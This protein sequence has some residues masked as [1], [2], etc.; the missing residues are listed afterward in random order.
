VFGQFR[1]AAELH[2]ARLSAGPS[3]AGAGADQIFLELGK[4]SIK[5]PCGVTVSARVSAKNGKPALLR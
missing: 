5:R 1:F 4:V 3:F 2:A